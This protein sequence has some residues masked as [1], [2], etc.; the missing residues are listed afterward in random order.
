[1]VSVLAGVLMTSN[2]TAQWAGP[3]PHYP[4]EP[5]SIGPKSGTGDWTDDWTEAETEALEDYM[6]THA[7]M[8]G[9]I[10]K[11]RR[12]FYFGVAIST[13]PGL[14]GGLRKCAW[15]PS[16]GDWECIYNA[17]CYCN[18]DPAC[19]PF[20]ELTPGY[21]TD[22]GNGKSAGFPF[23][24]Y[25]TYRDLLA[26]DFN[27]GGTCTEL[28]VPTP[29]RRKGATPY[30]GYSD[31]VLIDFD[32][33]N[34]MKG[35]GQTLLGLLPPWVVYTRLSPYPE[36]N[37][38]NLEEL[39]E[40]PALLA[41]LLFEFIDTMVDQYASSETLT[42][43]S[44]AGEA[45]RDN[46]P[47]VK[48][49]SS[50][51]DTD[52]DWVLSYGAE[53]LNGAILGAQFPQQY[54]TIGNTN[55]YVDVLALVDEEIVLIESRTGNAIHVERAQADTTAAT[56]EANA[57]L[58]TIKNLI[59]C[60]YPA[61]KPHTETPCAENDTACKTFQSRYW[62][63]HTIT[64]NE[65][66][67]AK[68]ISDVFLV[69]T[70]KRVRAHDAD[71]LLL[72][73]DYGCIF[74]TE[75][76]VVNQKFENVK[77]L[78]KLLLAS[79]AP[80]SGIGVEMFPPTWACLAADANGED[81][82]RLNP[83]QL[84]GIVDS[85]SIMAE[86]VSCVVIDQMDIRMGI[87]NNV[88]VWND[89]LEEWVLNPERYNMMYVRQLSAPWDALSARIDRRQEWQ[90]RVYKG[91]L[92][93]ALAVPK[94]YSVS[95]WGIIDRYSWLNLR[96]PAAWPW[97]PSEYSDPANPDPEERNQEACNADILGAEIEVVTNSPPLCT[98][99]GNYHPKPAYYGVREAIQNYF[100]TAFS[101]KDHDGNELVRFVNNGNVIIMK[102]PL[103]ENPTSWDS[104]GLSNSFI[105]K[106][107]NGTKKAVVEPDGE[108]F[109]AGEVDDEVEN[110]AMP[111]SGTAFIV[112][113]HDGD[114][115]SMIDEDGNLK[116]RGTVIVKGV[117]Y[118]LE[119]AHG[120]G[121]NSPDPYSIYP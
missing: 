77:A 41:N 107:H 87:P 49:A 108:M 115:V 13:R 25:Q 4:I 67:R 74:A 70:F 64:D 18:D 59:K 62:L 39:E 10:A 80:I 57:I 61:M 11:S 55:V 54:A 104:I 92:N 110:L 19:D 12:P 9:I 78:K 3:G 28:E 38:V 58:Y 44:V 40:A 116:A 111:E 16:D 60:E 85:L 120:T 112:K 76:N 15:K 90:G 84:R 26:F 5:I 34:G 98:M 101:V 29:F 17:C 23:K 8:R 56:H 7:G 48:L 53:A 103:N 73:I 93:A 79:G 30:F 121:S 105:V 63:W 21:G 99:S 46:V 32:V 27:Y 42:R 35:A 45:V 37:P 117:P 33:P 95:L 119:K 65:H 114:V 100:G 83:R 20:S 97:Y 82:L 2:A 81:G 24:R 109:L 71:A 50:V 6:D 89:E 91:I 106:D 68:D 88:Y 51:S 96:D 66:S 113:N 86:G 31:E 118:L 47:P 22:C 43:W 1:M 36:E 75:G 69:E 14:Y 72:Y 102:G 52:E 94:L